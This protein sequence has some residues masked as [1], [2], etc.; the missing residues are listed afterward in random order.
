MSSSMPR[1]VITVVGPSTFSCLMG[2]PRREQ[3][4]SIVSKESAH[5]EVSGAPAKK[6]SSK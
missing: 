6:K 3:R 2:T 5:W 4:E 1:K